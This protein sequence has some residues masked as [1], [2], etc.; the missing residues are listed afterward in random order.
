MTDKAKKAIVKLH[1]RHPYTSNQDWAD[2][3]DLTLKEVEDVIAKDKQLQKDIVR[4][5]KTSNNNSAHSIAKELNTTIS[6]VNVVLDNY[7]AG[8]KIG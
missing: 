3:Y 5:F 2:R 6:R 7:L 8:C 4:V 1:L